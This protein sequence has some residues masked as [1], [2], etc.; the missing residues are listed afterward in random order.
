MEE[1]IWVQQKNRMKNKFGKIR[2]LN[3]RVR[4][5]LLVTITLIIL[6]SFLELENKSIDTVLSYVFGYIAI[7]N[8][9]IFLRSLITFML[10][11]IAV[12]LIWGNYFDDCILGNA[13]VI[14]TR[15][16]QV[17]KIL[18]KYTIELAL[19]VS[20]M[21]AMLMGGLSTVYFLKGY[22]VYDARMMI[23]NCILYLIYMNLF[24]MVINFI[25]LS[26]NV[27]YSVLFVFIIQLG[28]LQCIYMIQKE[29]LAP[30]LYYFLPASPS[31]MFLNGG[32]NQGIKLIWMIYMI[33][34][35]FIVHLIGC[36]VMKKKEFLS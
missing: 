7:N 22:H 21:T 20:T 23:E 6:E 10:P 34:L 18:Q 27:M 1:H 35:M 13:N 9:N 30:S 4:G 33:G 28:F 17:G 12:A 25:S 8:Y 5:L 24:I 26:I 16:R 19:G 36:M 31:I 29:V 14:F 3:G 15:T 2:F 32:I 11:Q